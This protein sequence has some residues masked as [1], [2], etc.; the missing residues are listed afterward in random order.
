MFHSIAFSYFGPL[1]T[2]QTR[3]VLSVV[4]SSVKCAPIR[5]STSMR[6][7]ISLLFENVPNDTLMPVRFSIACVFTCTLLL[8]RAPADVRTTIQISYSCKTSK[9]ESFADVAVGDT[10]M[11][12][13]WPLRYISIPRRSAACKTS[14]FHWMM[15]EV[16]VTDFTDTSGVSGGC[17]K[18]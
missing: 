5:A 2:V 6:D 1:G 17:E 7:S 14:G 18:E 4:K 11:D 9:P 12:N 15:A 3:C 10:L 13:F 8:C 16:C